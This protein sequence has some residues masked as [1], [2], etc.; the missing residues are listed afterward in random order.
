MKISAGLKAAREVLETHG[1]CQGS[2]ARRN[3]DGSLSYC[4][5]GALDK[6][7]GHEVSNFFFQ[8]AWRYMKMAMDDT[9]SI[10]SWND[11]PRRT[12]TQVL[13]AFDR[14]AELAQENGN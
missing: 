8:K 5:L 13:A 3:D 4:S 10:A 9:P 2:L 12:K 11:H 6:A 1:W 7:V 14:A